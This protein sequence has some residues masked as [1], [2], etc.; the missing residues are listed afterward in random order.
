[1]ICPKCG[2]FTMEEAVHCISCGAEINPAVGADAPARERASFHTPQQSAA[3]AQ[4]NFAPILA[5]SVSNKNEAEAWRE[6][7]RKFYSSLQLQFMLLIFVVFGA[8]FLSTLSDNEE[9]QE[10]AEWVMGA[11][12]LWILVLAVLIYLTV[13]SNKSFQ[14]LKDEM[15]PYLASCEAEYMVVDTEKVYGSTKHGNFTLYF[16]QIENI[17]SFSNSLRCVNQ[18]VEPFSYTGLEIRDTAGNGYTFTT[19]ANAKE[20]CSVIESALAQRRTQ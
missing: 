20:L 13:V 9:M 18:N 2:S 4:A 7:V 8:C 19:F 5:R 6:K 1:M 3:H 16:H 15:T 11:V 17:R 14:Q 10:L 12:W